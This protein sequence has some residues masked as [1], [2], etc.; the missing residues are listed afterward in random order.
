MHD[1]SHLRNVFSFRNDF[2]FPLSSVDPEQNAASNRGL[3]CLPM[4]Q[5]LDDRHQSV[6]LTSHF[7]FKK[8]VSFI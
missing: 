1:I 7:I 2:M 8:E 4:S 6:D 3:H 5:L